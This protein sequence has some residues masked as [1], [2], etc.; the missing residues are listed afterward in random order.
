MRLAGPIR[1]L[2]AQQ[3][4]WQGAHAGAKPHLLQLPGRQPGIECL[5]WNPVHALLAL[6]GG[7]VRTAS[8]SGDAGTLLIFAPSTG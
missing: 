1:Y 5:A 6:T 3:Q 4:A 8:R 7:E 2:T